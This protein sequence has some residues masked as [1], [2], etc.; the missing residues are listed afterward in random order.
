MNEAIKLK[1]YLHMYREDYYRL[2]AKLKNRQL[3]PSVTLIQLMDTCD[4]LYHEMLM[5]IPVEHYEQIEELKRELNL[6]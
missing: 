5:L 2:N 1:L 4:M 3:F 6:V